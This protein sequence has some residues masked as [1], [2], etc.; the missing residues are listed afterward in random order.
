[1]TGIAVQSGEIAFDRVNI[2]RYPDI[3]DIHKIGTKPTFLYFRKG[4]LVNKTIGSI[5]QKELLDNIA[6]MLYQ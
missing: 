3:A 2:T 6:K 1:M 5:E 4:E